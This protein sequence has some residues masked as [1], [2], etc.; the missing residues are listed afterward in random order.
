MSNKE[1]FTKCQNCKFWKPSSL[2]NNTCTHP[3]MLKGYQH[4]KPP[5][6]GCVVE[7]DE[8]WAILTGPNFG[9][10]NAEPIKHYTGRRRVNGI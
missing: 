6:D 1:N 9:C 7:D 10:V 4:N 3:K 8:D 2:M 5:E